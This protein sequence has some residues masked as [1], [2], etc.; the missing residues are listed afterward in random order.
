MKNDVAFGGALSS[1][2]RWLVLVW[3]AGGSSRL[4]ASSSAVEGYLRLPTRLTSHPEPP[5]ALTASS[6]PNNTI[7]QQQPSNNPATTPQQPPHPAHPL[8][9]Q[10]QAGSHHAECLYKWSDSYTFTER[11]VFAVIV[12]TVL[13]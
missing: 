1:R 2:W 5:G 11:T 13:V 6:L 12:I 7:T 8:C 3:C 10:H 4:V 9:Q